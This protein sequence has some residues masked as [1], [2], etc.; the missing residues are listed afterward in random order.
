[1]NFFGVNLGSVKLVLHIW[2]FSFVAGFVSASIAIYLSPHWKHKSIRLLML[3]MVAVSVW[4]LA[5]GMELI[6]P[7]LVI[8]LWWVKVEYFGAV[9]VGVLIFS[10]IVTITW[11]KWQL[12]TTGYVLLSIV[13]VIVIIL[14]LTNSDHHLMWSIAWLDLGGR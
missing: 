13:P 11:K 5:Y 9:W 7:N 4:S 10:F 1:M 14:V 2:F 12:N 8:K 6:S 3:L